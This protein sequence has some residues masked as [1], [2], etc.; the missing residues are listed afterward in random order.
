M[1][2]RL[3]F[4]DVAKGIGIILVLMGHGT[5]FL[6]GGAYITAFYMA[7]FFFVA[8]YVYHPKNIS[9]KEAV[10]KRFKRILVPY[11]GYNGI[12]FVYYLLKKIVGGDF[13]I[14]DMCIAIS[15]VFYSRNSLFGS[16]DD[17][18]YFFRMANDPVWFLTAMCSA[19]AIFYLV[20]DRC[21]ENRK[22]C[23]CILLS[24]LAVAVAMSYLPFLLPWSIDSAPLFAFF[25]VVGALFGRAQFFQ[26]KHSAVEWAIMSVLIIASVVLRVWNGKTNLSVR[27]YGNW[28]GMSV[29]CV[30]A[31]GVLGSV[32]LIWICRLL[33]MCRPVE[34]ILSQIGQESLAIMALHMAIYQVVDRVFTKVFPWITFDVDGT[35]KDIA[36]YWGYGIT[37]ILIAIVVSIAINLVLRKCRRKIRQR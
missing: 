16:G 37:R 33:S 21:L 12:L 10:G 2:E 4:L 31:I 23:V 29:L 15:G 25:M 13:E 24:L 22:K 32:L 35:A 7:M 5:G 30:A 20:V 3:T 26:K 14:R 17:N 28:S 9:Y 34:T 1:K 19:S 6:F 18:I 36:V 8:G 11:F 27:V